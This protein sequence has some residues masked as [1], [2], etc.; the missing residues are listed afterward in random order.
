[1]YDVIYKCI[2]SVNSVDPKMHTSPSVEVKDISIWF[3][4]EASGDKF[5]DLYVS[6]LLGLGVICNGVIHLWIDDNLSLDVN[7]TVS[8]I[9]P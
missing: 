6:S 8:G 3:T 9:F 7:I 4:N 5:I 1:M 2:P